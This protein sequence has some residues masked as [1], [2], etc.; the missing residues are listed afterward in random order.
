MTRGRPCHVRAF[1]CSDRRILPRTIFSI[2]PRR[3]KG[4]F[5]VPQLRRFR[6]SPKFPNPVGGRRFPGNLDS[7]GNQAFRGG[8]EM[9]LHMN[10]TFVKTPLGFIFSYKKIPR[11]KRGISAGADYS[12][13]TMSSRKVEPSFSKSTLSAK[14]PSTFPSTR[15]VSSLEA[16]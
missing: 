8:Y 13:A 7:F 5:E 12:P 1:R 9:F 11:W 6:G 10:R 14:K 16:L 15:R 4:T 2:P 3:A